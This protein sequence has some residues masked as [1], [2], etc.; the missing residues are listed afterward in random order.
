MEGKNFYPVA[1]VQGTI[2][3]TAFYFLGISSPVL[4][5]FAMA[6]ASFLP[7]VGPFIFWAPASLYLYSS[8]AKKP[9]HSRFAPLLLLFPETIRR[10]QMECTWGGFYP[11]FPK[12]GFSAILRFISRERRGKPFS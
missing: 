12:G 7:L 8:G 5:G 4:W 9:R 10:I 6:R 1:L 11:P 2:G 3:G